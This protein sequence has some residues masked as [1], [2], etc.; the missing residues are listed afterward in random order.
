MYTVLIISCQNYVSLFHYNVNAA[1][2]TFAASRGTTYRFVNGSYRYHGICKAWTPSNDHGDV[3]NEEKRDV[4]ETS[5]V[6]HDIV[7]FGAFDG[8]SGSGSSFAS[9]LRWLS[10]DETNITIKENHHLTEKFQQFPFLVRNS[11]YYAFGHVRCNNYLILVGGTVGKQNDT[12]DT[13]FY[14]DFLSSIWYQSKTVKCKSKNLR[15]FS[16]YT[17]PVTQLKTR[18]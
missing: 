16:L 3:K 15:V 12:I 7:I 2:S 11:Q 10:V 4:E 17:V 13:I 6:V 14:F 9:S 8:E 5:A 18:T 1:E